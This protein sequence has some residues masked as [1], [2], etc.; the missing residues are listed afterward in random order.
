MSTHKKEIIEYINKENPVTISVNFLP[1]GIIPNFA[2][3]A[4]IKD[5]IKILIFYVKQ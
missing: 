3:L 4:I 2:F 1:E 5:M